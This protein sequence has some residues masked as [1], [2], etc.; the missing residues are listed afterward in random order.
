MGACRLP[1]AFCV[2]YYGM[3]ENVVRNVTGPIQLYPGSEGTRVTPW[4]YEQFLPAATKYKKRV[5]LQLYPNAQH[6]FHNPNCE[7]L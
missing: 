5:G 3:I 1:L 6:A 2:D 4:A 7:K